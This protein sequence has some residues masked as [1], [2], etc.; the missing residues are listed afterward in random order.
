L[1]TS[2]YLEGR[3]QE[4]TPPV[5]LYLIVSLLFFLLV[6]WIVRR[7]LVFEVVPDIAGEVRVLTELLPQLMFA[8]LPA[9]AFLLKILHPR[10][11]YFD[12]LIHALHLHTAAYFPL[13]LLLPLERAAEGNS[14]L[15][16]LQFAMLAY[17]MVYLF[18]SL[19]LVYCAGW[20]AVTIR[21]FLLVS[22]YAS[23]LASSLEYVSRWQG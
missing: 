17:L 3:R 7:G 22:A 4:Y 21:T 16:V 9:F 20:L 8:F 19:R 5:R 14:F 1:L 10:R 13:A 6:A 11:F 23:L 18:L 12:H 15:L 2:Q